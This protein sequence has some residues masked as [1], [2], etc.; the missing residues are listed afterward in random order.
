MNRARAALGPKVRPW[1]QQRRLEFIDFRL[2]WEGRINRA[3][4]TD[5]FGISVPQAS[6]DL[7]EYQKLAPQ[8]LVYER[9]EKV[10]IATA[11]FRPALALEHSDSFLDQ[12]SAVASGA[13]PKDTFFIGWAPPTDLVRAPRRRVPSGVLKGVLRAIQHNLVLEVTYQVTSQP[14]P[15]DARVSPHAIAFDGMRWLVRAY[16]HMSKTFRNFGLGRLLQV[17]AISGSDA[18]P[19]S[20]RAWNTFVE[21]KVAP[22]PDLSGGQR[23]AI[24]LDY[25]MSGGVAVLPVRVALLPY[26]LRQL[27]LSPNSWEGPQVRLENADQLIPHMEAGGSDL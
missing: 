5:H 2:Y 4:L 24:E 18:V 21:V 1:G 3:D 17:E 10:Y 25:G 9:R 26:L 27:D 19:A 8:N 11:S 12:L 6:L 7:A 23:R 13:L 16:C 22:K 14:S 20:D 15:L